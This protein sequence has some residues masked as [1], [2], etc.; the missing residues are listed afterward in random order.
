[1]SLNIISTVLRLFCNPLMF[2]FRISVRPTAVTKLYF[3][4]QPFSNTAGMND[5]MARPL[6]S[7]VLPIFIMFNDSDGLRGCL[8][9]LFKPHWLQACSVQL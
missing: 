9:N 5:E 7:H 8:K 3:L 6:F 2:D 1:M 4:A